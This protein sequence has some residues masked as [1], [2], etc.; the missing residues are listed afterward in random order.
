MCINAEDEFVVVHLG[1]SAKQA[2]P[3][4]ENITVIRVGIRQYVMVVYPVHS[5]RDN[6]PAQRII[7]PLG[8]QDVGMVEL[9]KHQRKRLIHKN[10]TDRRSTYDD[11][12]RGKYESENAFSR[13]VPVGSGRI[14]VRIRMVYQVESPHPFYA[15]FHPVDK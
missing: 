2:I 15:V 10:Q 6:D 13:V 11:A 8:D 5:R 3:N 12:K 7:Q 14:H 1:K 4:R 9:G